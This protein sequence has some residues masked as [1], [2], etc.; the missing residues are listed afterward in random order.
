LKTNFDLGVS[1][2]ACGT[3]KYPRLLLRSCSL[4]DHPPAIKL[5]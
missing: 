3:L 5:I 1:I 4:M 2:P